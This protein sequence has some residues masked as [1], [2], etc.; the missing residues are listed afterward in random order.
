MATIG[1]VKAVFTASTA[2]LVEPVDRS[3][4]A[5][6][7]MERAISGVATAGR[8]VAAI[9]V[10]RVFT[11]IASTAVG[12]VRSLIGIG[13]AAAQSIDDVS[14]LSRK[15]GLTYAELA[16]LSHAGNLAGVSMELIGKAAVK[17]DVAFVRAAQGSTTA[18]EALAGLRLTVGGLQGMTAADRFLAISKAIS[19]IPTPAERSAAAVKLFGKAGAE[20]TP[21]FE[22]GAGAIQ[23]AYLEAQKFGMALSNE[24]GVAVENMN[25]AWDRV[26][27]SIGG[28]VAQVTA[29]LAPAVQGIADTFTNFVGRIGGANIGQVIG[30]GILR[31]ARGLAIV[32]DD[33]IAQ[34][35]SFFGDFSN[36]FSAMQTVLDGAYRLTGLVQALV[37]AIATVF[38]AIPGIF[39]SAAKSFTQMLGITPQ[40]LRDYQSALTG[41]FFFTAGGVSSG[42][43]MMTG[44]IGTGDQ[45]NATG[46]KL[47]AALDRFTAQASAMATGPSRA[48]ATTVA[49]TPSVMAAQM[50]SGPSSTALRGVLSNTSEGISE[51]LRMIR[52]TR[53]DLAQQQLE[54]T[55]QV[56]FNTDP[57]N[58][59]REQQ[60]ALE[61]AW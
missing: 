45:A 38:S 56:A 32:A 14:K 25:D 26:R 16:A 19:N 2:G 60:V 41:N 43:G 10:G 7:R 27:A 36:T 49:E 59:A 23:A 57:R 12:A 29:R 52:G 33:M 47:T 24:Q 42:F 54:A 50:A 22:E 53:D 55:Q 34:F 4:A 11:S 17:A 20:L 15:L 8:I 9:E 40:W 58:S 28:I 18:Q 21:L 44:G 46:G 35:Q 3:T 37:S 51:M 13:Q 30:D 48:T 5:L 6:A 1:K 31:G 39:S 61:I